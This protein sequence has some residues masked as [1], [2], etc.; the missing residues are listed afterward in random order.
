MATSTKTNVNRAGKQRHVRQLR[1]WLAEHL[2]SRFPKAEVTCLEEGRNSMLRDL[3][4]RHGLET[5]WPESSTWSVT[6]DAVV[7]IRCA[8]SVT[9]ALAK[10][11]SDRIR[12]S[13]VGEMVASCEV[14]RPTFAFLLAPDGLSASLVTLLRRFGRWDILRYG[15]QYIRVGTWDSANAEPILL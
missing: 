11:K 13:H 8:S 9:L 6:M 2:R 5:N 14:I 10:L 1:Q 12:I 3:V 4:A 15:E 7:L